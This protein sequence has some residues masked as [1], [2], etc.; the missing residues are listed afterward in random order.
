MHVLFRADA[1][2]AAGSGH[3]MRSLALA[4][5]VAARGAAVTLMAPDVPAAVEAAASAGV[6]FVGLRGG[7]EPIGAASA[8]AS[9]WTV[10]D[11]YGF[12]APYR[13]AIRAAGSRVA[14]IDDDGRCATEA[15]DAVLNQNP[16]AWRIPYRLPP[17]SRVLLGT[18]FALLAPAFAALPPPGD[19]APSARRLLVTFGGSDPSR[20]TPAALDALD[21]APAEAFDTTVVVGAGNSRRDEIGAR[22]DAMA[23]GGRAIR[24]VSATPAAMARLMSR[25]DMAIAAAGTTLW[26]LAAAGVPALVVTV[27]ANQVAPAKAAETIGSVQLLGGR[28]N[29][30][31]AVMG[32]ALMALATH[33]RRRATMR[34]RGRLMIDGQGAA[35]VAAAMLNPQAGWQVARAR[36]EDA[37]VMWE[38]NGNPDARAQSFS[39]AAIPLADHL[40][41]YSRKLTDP[42]SAMFTISRDEVVAGVIRYD[43]TGD[44][45]L[46]SY[47]L[48]PA[49]RGQGLGTQ[50]LR[51]TTGPARDALGVSRIE[52]LVLERNA[53][54]SGAFTNAGFVESGVREH[55]GR[56][57][58][59]WVQA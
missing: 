46:L 1:G 39:T 38:I 58:A 2:E 29:V 5:A 4:H 50:L 30:T 52:G 18:R 31:S 8:A 6:A 59:V 20:L 15:L 54:S 19:V 24:T 45:A 12:D 14:A 17:D 43:R 10:V 13:A 49:F 9:E 26:E 27:A 33:A 34:E 51:E 48:A 11:G 7:A 32:D 47:A 42:A 21:R 36:P 37:L 22:V 3:V 56:R 55:A 41:W 57:C 28:D 25:A 35:R 44:A 40:A 16:S 23:R 53:A